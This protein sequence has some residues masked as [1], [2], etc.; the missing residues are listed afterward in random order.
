MQVSDYVT[1][2]SQLMMLGAGLGCF[3][4]LIGY[5]FSFIMRSFLKGGDTNG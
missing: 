5:V 1:I 4:I 2:A 3:V